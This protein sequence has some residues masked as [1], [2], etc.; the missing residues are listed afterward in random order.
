QPTFS[1]SGA[2]AEYRGVADV[3]SESCWIH[4]LL[5][6]LDFPIP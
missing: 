6:E 3:V 4:N 1:R 2:E 5:L